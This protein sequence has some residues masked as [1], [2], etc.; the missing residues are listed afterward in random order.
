MSASLALAGAVLAAA[1]VTAAAVVYHP[2]VEA[3]VTDRFR[4]PATA[5]GRGNRGLEY[6]TRPGE[7]VRAAAP[8]VVAFAGLVGAA[9]HVSVVHADGLRTTYSFL[10]SVRVRRGDR[11]GAGDPI[12]TAGDRVHLGAKVGDAYLD[13]ALLFGNDP[14]NPPR[15]ARLVRDEEGDRDAPD[16]ASQEG[17]RARPSLR[18]GSRLVGH[19]DGSRPSVGRYVVRQPGA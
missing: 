11:V 15:R 5:Y 7:V 14:P 9:L 16:A 2:P 13:P 4:P 19:T 17:H 18:R 12:G 3:P 10:A 1:A 6:A 8:G